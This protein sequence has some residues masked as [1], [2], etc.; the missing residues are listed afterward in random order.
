MMH[1]LIILFYKYKIIYAVCVVPFPFCN[2]LFL[3]AGG[4]E[5]EAG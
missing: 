3:C 1:I 2:T 4:G 5:E